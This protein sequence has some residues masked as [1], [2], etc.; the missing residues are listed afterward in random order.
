MESYGIEHFVNL[1]SDDC[2]SYSE[3]DDPKKNE[4]KEPSAGNNEEATELKRYT[5]SKGKIKA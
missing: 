5:K 1:E 2:S 4:T 3:S